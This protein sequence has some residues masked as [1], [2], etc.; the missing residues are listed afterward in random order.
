M[1]CFH[2][3]DAWRAQ[4]GGITFT[5]G[6]GWSDRPLQINC[7]QCKGCRLHHSEMWAIRCTHEDQTHD[8]SAYITLTYNDE[9]LPKDRSVDVKVWQAFAKKLRKRIGPFRFFH[10]GEYS[11]EG[12]PHYHALIFGKNFDEDK[13][14]I[15]RS[16]GKLRHRLYTSPLLEEVWGNGFVSIGDVTFESAAYVA[17]YVMKKVTGKKAEEDRTY[18]R[19]D[20]GTGECWD[21]KPEYITMSRNPG[22]GSDWFDKFSGDVFPSDEVRING[23]KHRVPRFYDNKISE[24][25]LLVFKDKRFKKAREGAKD[26]TPDRLATREVVLEKKIQQLKR[27]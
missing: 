16:K 12:R 20:L 26:L 1:P 11:E 2:P 23:K 4:G 24:E 5:K 18:E 22:I 19:F 8:K 14:Y 15:G 27:S 21:V 7:G 3:M 6:D 10:C 17:R 13:V 25:D 9:N